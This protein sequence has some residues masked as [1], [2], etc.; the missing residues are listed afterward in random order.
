MEEEWKEFRDT[1]LKSAT[2]VC[3]YI[4]AR[5]GIREGRDGK[6]GKVVLYYKREWFSSSGYRKVE[7]KRLKVECKNK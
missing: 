2:K 7:R 1:A 5:Q 3:W 6:I 4:L